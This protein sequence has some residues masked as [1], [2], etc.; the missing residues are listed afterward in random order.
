V[1]GRRLAQPLAGLALAAVLAGCGSA[2]AQPHRAPRLA[3][4]TSPAAR[5]SPNGVPYDVSGLRFPAGGKFLGVETP[6]PPGALGQVRRFAAAIGRRP[7]IIGEYVGWYSPFKVDA[8]AAIWN[9]G[10]LPFLQWEPFGTTLAGIAAGRTD[11]YIARFARAIRALNLPVALSFGHEMNGNWYPWG[12]NAATPA[13][14]VAAWRHVHDL[15]ARYGA[16][17]VI[18]VWNPN[19]IDAL[20]QVQL[21]PYYPGDSYVDWVGVTGYF[22]P[23]TN[24]TF[25][26][27]YGPTMTEIRAFT[28][29]PFI[30]PET[31]VASGPHTLA[32][33]ASILR[34]IAQHHDQLGVVWF[35]YDKAGVDWR[36]ESRPA[37]RLALARALAGMALLNVGTAR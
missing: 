36:A 10:A 5:P 37:V 3:S 33:V 8:A 20:P 7:N 19:T 32:S 31:S 12:V 18:W 15:F 11:R 4:A 23:G 24:V 13:Q 9:Y 28:A 34:T 30:I 27:L 25:F 21:R 17:N 22:T 29:K 2:A 35:E 6:G 14:F 16:T 1:R 26:G